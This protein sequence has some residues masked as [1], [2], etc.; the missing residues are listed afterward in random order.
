MKTHLIYFSPTGTTKKVVEVIGSKIETTDTKTYDLTRSS[1]RVGKL[2]FDEE[3]IVIVGVPV[4]AGRIPQFLKS[5]FEGLKGNKT[6]VV[7]VVLYGNRNYDDALLELKSI[8]D[9]NG[10]RGIGAGAFIGEHSRTKKVATNRP[11]VEDICIAKEFGEK[12]NKMLKNQD[13]FGELTVKGNFPF[14]EVDQMPKIAPST[15]DGCV[16]CGVCARS[17]PMDA[18]NISNA[19][20]VDEQKC[21]VCASCVK[22][23]HKNAK[24]FKQEGIAKKVSM[25]EANL[26]NL[27]KKPEFFGV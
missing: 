9:E 6:K 4:Y 21:I 25:L 10:F 19:K 15:D 16:N 26:A 23:C 11:D 18:I 3:D 17:C 8:F 14:R 13:G 27:R 20:E 24:A 1:N 5:V 7:F 22:K 12:I 2:S